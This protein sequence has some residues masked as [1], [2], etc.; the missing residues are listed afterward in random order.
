M[1][2]RFAHQLFIAQRSTEWS[3]HS[4]AKHVLGPIPFSRFLLETLQIV[5]AFALIVWLFS[6]NAYFFFSF[7]ED[8]SLLINAK[9]GTTPWR[10]SRWTFASQYGVLPSDTLCHR[11]VHSRP[12]AGPARYQCVVMKINVLSKAFN[13]RLLRVVFG[14]MYSLLRE[15]TELQPLPNIAPVY[16]MRT[17]HNIAH[18][19]NFG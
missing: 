11:S 12:N 6:K 15:S 19:G 7:N 18:F 4:P 13:T 5:V 17:T 14:N 2:S 16:N 8:T 9:W 3:I 1:N 10:P